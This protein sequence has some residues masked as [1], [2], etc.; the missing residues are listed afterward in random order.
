MQSA[1][2]NKLAL[3]LAEVLE[4]KPG[5]AACFENL[6]TILQNEGNYDLA[7][8]NFLKSLSLC[9][10]TGNKTGIAGCLN[11][12][13]AIHFYLKNYE[14][15]LEYWGQSLSMEKKSG[16][17]K[18]IAVMLNNIGVVYEK[19][20]D[21]DKALEHHHESLKFREEAG[22]K[23]GIAQSN[24]NIAIIY[25]RRE[26]FQE[27]INYFEK[28]LEMRKQLGD[29]R[30]VSQ[31]TG[32]IGLLYLE[33]A[34]Y[35]RK[36][37]IP[38]N[39]F[40]AKYQKAK[41][42]IEE[43]LKIAKDINAKNEIK[44][45]YLNLSEIYEKQNNPDEALRYYK[46]Y[47]SIKDTLFTEE[48]SGKIA[49]MDAKYQVEKAKSEKEALEKDKALQGASLKLQRII[50][51]S[52]AGG[53]VLLAVFVFF[54][55][56]SNKQKQVVNIQLE[57]K[58]ASIKKAGEEIKEKSKEITDSI[59]YAQQIQKAILPGDEQIKKLLPNSFV[60]FK[61]HSIVSGDF[62]WI[63]ERDGKIIFTASDCTGHGVPGAFMSVLCT[64]LLNEAVNEKGITKPNEIFY[65][66]RKGII[67]SLKQTG[68]TGEQQDGMDSV[69]C[70]LDMK[71]KTIEFVCAN[72]PLYLIRGWELIESEKDKQ[73]VGFLTV[74]QKPFKNQELKLQK[75]DTIYLFSDG[76]CDQFGGPNDKRF[77]KKRFKEL[78]L[79]LQPKSMEEQKEILDKT[80]EEWKGDRE[81][82]DDIL[83]IGVRFA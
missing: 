43:S 19:Q 32:N 57:Q 60:L 35:Q 15:T 64:S 11:N 67:N 8:S 68:E 46:L 31:T 14:K 28:S 65:E 80:I 72:N 34:E 56:R 17:T 36:K 76:Y 74:E 77:M 13:G 22:D 38:L 5:I 52:A 30:G 82:T 44:Y 51:W 61:P 63:T 42:Y 47:S 6:G 66:V 3:T 1:K 24:Q 55:Y 10:E 16:N 71:S 53:I 78:L 83:I 75:D 18:R 7:L 27:A 39:I 54:I 50:I 49:E 20:K 62:Y 48:S 70:A 4:Y 33:W 40:T 9:E 69:L 21:F 23:A 25:A 29:K 81:Q 58:N 59:R 37:D 79:S 73:P 12:I 41:N 26:K 45:A 2:Y